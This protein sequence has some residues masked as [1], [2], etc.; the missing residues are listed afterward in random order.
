MPD[1]SVIIPVYNAEKYLETCIESIL[2]SSYTNFELILVDDGSKDHSGAICDRYALTDKRVKV[3]HKVNG[4]VGVARN[5]GLENATGEWIAFVDSDDWITSDYLENLMSHTEN[6]VDLVV[7]FPE[8]FLKSDSYRIDR[9]LGCRINADNFGQMFASNDFQE[10]TSPWGKLFR[11]SVVKEH[12]IR[13]DEHMSFGE[14]TVFLYTFLLYVGNIIVSDKIGYCYRGE[15]EGSLSKRIN[16]IDVE[17]VNYVKIHKTVDIL[18]RSRHITNDEALAKL[19]QL[20]ATYIWRTLN[21]LY[22][23]GVGREKRM[24]TIH[25]LDMSVLACKRST[26]LKDTI[27]LFMLRYRL[28][29]MYDLIRCAMSRN[30]R[31][32]ESIRNQ[33]ENFNRQ[34]NTYEASA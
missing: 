30:N 27:I 34:E 9:Y 19:K 20:V 29:R 31:R 17:Y 4:G 1:I 33:S 25:S 8:V 32:N 26:C 2:H 23:S 24:Q 18:I 3:Y 22:H 15:I 5:I 12:H 13:F 21:S 16:P 10:H 11:A 28:F 7:S 14:D 6:V